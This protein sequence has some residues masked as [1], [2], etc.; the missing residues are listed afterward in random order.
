MDTWSRPREVFVRMHVRLF[1]SMAH[2]TCMHGMLRWAFMHAL[3]HLHL[4]P[5]LTL[6]PAPPQLHACVH[7]DVG[8]LWQ[9]FGSVAHLGGQM[10][11]AVATAKP[12]VDSLEEEPPTSL[13]VPSSHPQ[14]PLRVPPAGLLLLCLP[15]TL[16]YLGAPS[17][18]IPCT[19]LCVHCLSPAPAAWPAT[20]S[21]RWRST[22]RRSHAAWP[23]R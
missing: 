5:C 7:A 12:A 1:A 9:G 22:R 16:R 21:A 15:A 19:S 14:H 10:V 17:G 6:R 4:F 20:S 23:R 3:L 11:M 18:F 2:R 13:L 8:M